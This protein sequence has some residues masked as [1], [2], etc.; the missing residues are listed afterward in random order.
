[1]VALEKVEQD[2]EDKKKAAAA[3]AA[4][5]TSQYNSALSAA[6][7]SRGLKLGPLAFDFARSVYAEQS[8][9]GPGK[10]P[11]AM[12][13]PAPPAPYTPSSTLS[14][15]LLIL[16]PEIL[17]SDFVQECR[18]EHSLADHLRN[19]FP[20]QTDYAPWDEKKQSVTLVCSSGQP[21]AG[22]NSPDGARARTLTNP[23]HSVLLLVLLVLLLIGTRST[24]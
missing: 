11:R 22:W 20:P 24:I 10:L 6:L 2:R 21:C 18:E 8:K 16:Y 15:P 14:W 5:A 1:V 4:L 9:E 23:L 17:Q 19:M 7:Q 12:L 13:H 3:A